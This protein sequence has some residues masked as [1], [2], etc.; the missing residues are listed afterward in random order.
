MAK[1]QINDDLTKHLT[2]IIPSS[3]QKGGLYLGNQI[4]AT[5]MELLSKYKITSIITIAE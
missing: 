1:V 3:G 5:N 2:E 4:A